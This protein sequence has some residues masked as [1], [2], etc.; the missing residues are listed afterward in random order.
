MNLWIYIR[1]TLFSSLKFIFCEVLPKTPSACWSNRNSLVNV[2]T[3]LVIQ[4][5]MNIT[6]ANWR[7]EVIARFWCSSF[8]D[9]MRNVIG[10]VVPF[11]PVPSIIDEPTVHHVIS[12]KETTEVGEDK[13]TLKRRRSGTVKMEMWKMEKLR[14]KSKEWNEL[15]IKNKN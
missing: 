11:Q 9:I 4:G 3:S 15:R 5:F 14:M 2:N 10:Y 6:H 1:K 13:Q 8:N 12:Q 7:Q